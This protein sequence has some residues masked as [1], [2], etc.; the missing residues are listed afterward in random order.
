MNKLYLLLSLI[1]IGALSSCKQEIEALNEISTVQDYTWVETAP[2]ERYTSPIP[3]HAIG[4]IGSDKEV[5]LSFK[6]GGVISQLSADEGDYV[7]AGQSLASIRTNEIDAQVLK[8]RQGVEKAQRDLDRIQL[9]YQDSAAT[10]ENVQDLSTMVELRQAD[11]DIALFNQQY[12]KIIS[13]VNGRILSR[14]AEPNELVSPGQPIYIISSSSNGSYVMTASL[15]DRDISLISTGDKALVSF[16]AYPGDTFAGSVIGVDESADPR[17]G[18]F[19]VDIAIKTNGR[20]MRNGLI[21]RIEIL[22]KGQN[23]YI[24]I[25]LDAVVEADHGDV[26]LFTPTQ[27]DTIAREWRVQPIRISHTHILVEP[28]SV[29]GDRVITAGAPYLLDGDRI[30]VK[31]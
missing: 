21:G 24:Q 29:S 12:A 14:I 4:R 17:T 8:A 13:P 15:S 7:R 22:P 10:L 6:I 9:M 16:D 5:K 1:I 2:I 31:S 18:T 25:P 11:L 26:I 23:D 28:S 19:G 3:I 30:K 20:R 27:S